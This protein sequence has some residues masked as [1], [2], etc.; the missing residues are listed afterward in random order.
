MIRR[1][2][3]A[4]FVLGRG[5]VAA[6]QGTPGAS[7]C[8]LAGALLVSRLRRGVLVSAL[9]ALWSTSVLAQEAE[10]TAPQAPPLV[11]FYAPL[12]VAS[13]AD[14]ARSLLARVAR[15]RGTAV[16][17]VSPPKPPE[18]RAAAQLER[19]ISA[20]HRFEEAQAVA[21]IEAVLAE[22]E[23]TGAAG[24]SARMLGD[25]FLYGAL[26]AAQQGDSALAWE[27]WIQAATLDPG[28]RLD[29]VR[30]PPGVVDT[31]ERA[32]KAVSERPWAEVS[33]DADASCALTLDAQPVGAGEWA[34]VVRGRHY[35]HASCPGRASYGARVLVAEERAVV[36]PVFASPAPPSAAA[37]RELAGR[38]GADMV[39]AA[40]VTASPGTTPTLS[41]VLLDVASGRERVRV[42]ASL[43]DLDADATDARDSAEARDALARS[44]ESL[45]DQVGSP[46]WLAEAAPP[47]RPWYRR[48]WVWGLA[49]AA[50]GAAIVLPFLLDDNTAD[51]FDARL[52]GQP[53]R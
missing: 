31:F 46:D 50:V 23:V 18:P 10:A 51:G 16:I 9:V 27:R 19:A 29:P 8:G 21:A 42:F 43:A 24:L 17:D 5:R 30:F 6:S 34:R 36:R 44:L 28:R 45:I 53:S 3:S 32:L 22:V 1:K 33:I 41:L 39:I 48:P 49:G 20:Y 4:V 40:L 14:I 25:A 37:V 35:V 7:L 47:P 2:A 52:G 15:S 11:V 13:E 12:R 26:I 38:R